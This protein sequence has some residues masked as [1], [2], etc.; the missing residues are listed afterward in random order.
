MLAVYARLTVF[1][2]TCLEM[3]G[4]ALIKIFCDEGLG[5]G[6]IEDDAPALR[7]SRHSY[8]WLTK[9]R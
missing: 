4:S 5:F 9:L 2:E 1:G 6:R 8:S 3:A 7:T